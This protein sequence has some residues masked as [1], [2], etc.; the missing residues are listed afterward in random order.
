MLLF[1]DLWKVDERVIQQIDFKQAGSGS[2]VSVFL[3]PIDFGCLLIFIAK[4]VR[5]MK[6]RK[7]FFSL[8][9]ILT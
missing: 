6:K 4:G 7:V 3:I 9:F 8:I 5:K 2:F 1:E